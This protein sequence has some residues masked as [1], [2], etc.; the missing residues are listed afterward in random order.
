MSQTLPEDM[1]P[2][3]ISAVS[4]AMVRTRLPGAVVDVDELTWRPFGRREPVL[5]GISLHIEAGSR[6]LLA[7]PSGSGKST[8]LRALAGVLTATETGVLTG[9][10][11][12]DGLRPAGSSVGLMMQ[13]PADALVA[14]RVGRDVAFGPESFGMPRAQ[15]W[16]RVRSALASVGF[17]YD[18][19]HPTSALSGG[20]TQRLALAGV[21]ALTPRLVLLDE[22]TSMLDPAAAAR[23]R[24]AIV[25]AVRRS[26]ATLVMV[27][28]RLSDWVDEVDRLVVLD[29]S[30][31]VSAHGPVRPTLAMNADSLAAQGVWVP[32]VPAPIGTT[33]V[34]RAGVA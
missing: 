22:P 4:A 5:A 29:R 24:A 33:G 6:V 14:G 11:L 9:S 27:E 12:I 3:F 19:D 32:G 25:S 26:G 17:P 31:R 13:D 30:G 7:G 21:L 10:V 18:V 34:G 2:T 16:S 15:I 1:P 28:H 23:V 8:L 20:E